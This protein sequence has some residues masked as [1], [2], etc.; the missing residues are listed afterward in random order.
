MMSKATVGMEDE[1]KWEIGDLLKNRSGNWAKKR[2]DR[3]KKPKQKKSSGRSS[4]LGIQGTR[5]QET[6]EKGS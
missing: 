5:N 4:A 6:K 3:Q 2:S 1:K